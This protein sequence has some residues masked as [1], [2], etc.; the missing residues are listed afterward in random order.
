MVVAFGCPP[1]AL[2]F[3]PKPSPR[4]MRRGGETVFL[5]G[6]NRYKAVQSI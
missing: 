4:L 6:R 5:S 2:S 3:V 1:I